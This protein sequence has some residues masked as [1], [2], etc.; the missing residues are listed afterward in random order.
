MRC[1]YVATASAT[2]FRFSC[3]LRCSKCSFAQEADGDE[4]TDEA[5]AAFIASEGRWVAR[6]RDPGPR[7]SDALHALRGLRSDPP[8]ELLRIVREG[9]PLAE[10]ARAEA[11]Y[12]EEA[13]KEFG[14]D[15]EVS[16]VD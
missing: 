16:R 2:K 11:E 13:L 5:R 9:L 1:S 3:S 8:L 15:V 7:R 6:V 14:V 10:G 12:F 4:L